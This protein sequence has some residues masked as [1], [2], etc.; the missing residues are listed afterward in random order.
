MADDSPSQLR[1]GTALADLARLYPWLDEVT[2]TRGWSSRFLN[3][4]HVALEE[5]VMNVAMHAFPTDQSGEIVVTF[6]VRDQ[7]AFLIVEDEGVPFDPVAAEVADP[8]VRIQEH[9][10]GGLGLTLMRH[11]CQNISYERRNGRNT[12]TLCFEPPGQ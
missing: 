6:M 8:L 3:G 9:P 12:L 5:A 11:F 4:M 10:P 7:S 1:I 2:A